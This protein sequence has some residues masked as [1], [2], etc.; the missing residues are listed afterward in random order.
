MI[1][2]AVIV[3]VAAFVATQAV[4]A[5]Q[6]AAADPADVGSPEAVVKALYATVNRAPGAR[7]DW[8]R[9]RTLLMPSAR[10]IPN[11]EQTGGALRILTVDEFVAW[12]D[13]NTVVGGAND[14]GFQEEEIATRI[15]RFGDIAHAFSTYQKHFYGSSQ[16]LGR[17][18]NSIQMHFHDGRWWIT[19]LVWDEENGA[20]AIPRRYLPQDR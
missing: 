8:P 13:A 6:S 2:R 16:I 4:H 5:Q 1:R 3:I 17:G 11:S 7:Y 18:I 20:G 14:L 19:Q 12:I 10:M 9:L 15:E